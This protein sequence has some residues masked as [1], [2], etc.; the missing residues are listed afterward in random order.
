MLLV[1][2]RIYDR[3]EYRLNVE[4]PMKICGLHPLCNSPDDRKSYTPTPVAGSL[5]NP[6]R[7]R[8]RQI[9]FLAFL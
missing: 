8:N 2:L 1:R 4:R 6:E 3:Q 9:L 5:P 7:V